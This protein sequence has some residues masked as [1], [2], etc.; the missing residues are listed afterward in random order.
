MNAKRLLQDIFFS[1]LFNTFVKKSL[2]HTNIYNNNLLKFSNTVNTLQ[3]LHNSPF[4]D[5]LK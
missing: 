4:K 3:L 2:I 1:N 5:H